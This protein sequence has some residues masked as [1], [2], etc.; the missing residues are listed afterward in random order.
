M[1]RTGTAPVKSGVIYFAMIFALG[2]VLGTVRVLWLVPAIGERNAVLAELPVMLTA[3]WFA[4]RWL[5]QRHRLISLRA[6]A[7]MGL[8]GFALLMLAEL[9]LAIAAFGQ[10]AA[11]W[12][13]SIFAMPGII[14][15]SGQIL[16][17]LM[18]MLVRTQR[19]SNPR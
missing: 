4:A 2:F 15:L 18:P 19:D 5:V 11:D 9:T 14:G 13:N 10:S 7:V 6:R 1:D 3:S 8:V 16:F 17:A 12:L